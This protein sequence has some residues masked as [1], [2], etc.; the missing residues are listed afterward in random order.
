MSTAATAASPTPLFPLMQPQ[1]KDAH[2]SCYWVYIWRILL[3]EKENRIDFKTIGWVIKNRGASHNLL[4]LQP[5][6]V[7]A[8]DDSMP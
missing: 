6:R 8:R 4:R 3:T 7:G 2:E 1:R 5:I